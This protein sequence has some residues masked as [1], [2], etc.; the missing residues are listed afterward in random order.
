[1]SLKIS[2]VTPTYNSALYI[3]ETMESIH[4]Q[5]YKNFEHIVMD[6]LS[7]DNTVAIVEEYPNAKVISEKDSGQ[8]DALNKGFKLV[9]GDILA[10]QNA[11]DLYCPNAFQ[12][13]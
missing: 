3:R 6:G 5:S 8:S 2:I 1:M 4:S 12:T 11:D 13:V 10:W 9:T 7:K